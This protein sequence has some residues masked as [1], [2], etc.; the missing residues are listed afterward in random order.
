MPDADEVQTC[1]SGPHLMPPRHPDRM[2]WIA[3]GVILAV[4]LVWL[5]RADIA[6]RGEGFVVAAL[7]IAVLAVAGTFWTRVK[8]EPQLAAMALSTAA[9]GSF[10]IAIA[11]LHYLMAT[12][13]RPLI[14]AG[15]AGWESRLG[16]DWPGYIGWIEQ[17][18]TLAHVLAQAYHSSGPQVGLVVVALSAARQ[19]A[20]LWAFARMFAV[21]LFVAIAVSCLFPAEGPYAFYGVAADPSR[22]ET[23][24]A[25]WHLDALHALRNGTLDSL[26]LTDIRGLVTFPSFHVCL[27]LLTIWALWRVPVLNLIATVVNAAI[28]V[29]TL[30]AGGHYLPDLLA[31]GALAVLVIVGLRGHALSLDSNPR[32]RRIRSDV[33]RAPS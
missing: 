15:L 30:S 32:S 10:T 22:L 3:A 4:D 19:F 12:L 5:A 25:V 13:D 1:H 2:I 26:A 11:V 9:L 21:A 18:G 20:R 24:G 27:A 28:I 31:G 8:P 16:F 23:L 17:H 29:A 7:V 14:D 33:M 6:L